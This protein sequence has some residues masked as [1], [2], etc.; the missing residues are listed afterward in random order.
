[1]F[2]GTSFSVGVTE[3]ALSIA[4]EYDKKVYSFNLHAERRDGTAAFERRIRKV[5][6][7]ECLSCA[8]FFSDYPWIR[9][10]LGPSEKTLPTLAYEMQHYHSKPRLWFYPN[11]YSST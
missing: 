7:N 9:H 2:V 10:I 11:P 4:Q 3:K 6:K 8:M 1:M 5:F